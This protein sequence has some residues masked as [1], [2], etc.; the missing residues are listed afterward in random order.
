[1]DSVFKLVLDACGGMTADEEAGLLSDSALQDPAEDQLGYAAFAENLAETIDEQMPRQDFVVGVYGPW[2]AGKSTILNFVEYYLRE[3]DEPPLL[4][5]FNPWWFSGQ[6]DL[7]RKFFAQLESGLGADSRFEGVREKLA[8]FSSALSSVPLDAGGVPSEPILTLLAEALE[9]ESEDL[10]SLKTGIAEELEDADRRIVVLI[11]DIDRLTEEEIKQMFRLVK[12]VADFPNITYVLAFDQEV[13][14]NA[15]E[16][17]QG[18]YSGEAYLD[19]II[20]L[21]KHVPIPAEGT[22]DEFFT[23][24]LDRL[25]QDGDPVFDQQHWQNLY[26]RGIQPALE[27][28]RHT[29]GGTASRCPGTRQL[30]QYR[31]RR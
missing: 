21:P 13:V 18:V 20:Q 14:V 10:D 1:M 12:S 30:L 23:S 3:Q 4:I 25:L 6:A 5:R 11:D 22:L 19:K 8:S 26:G 24:R 17:E 7:I 2:G 15:L 31:L 9:T 27:T 28:P 16:G 29:P